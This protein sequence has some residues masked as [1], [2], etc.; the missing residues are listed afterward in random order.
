MVTISQKFE[1]LYR[2]LNPEQKKAVDHIEGPVMVV[3]GP[4]TG[5]TQVL[6]LRIANILLK[7]QVNPGNILAL[8]FSESGAATMRRRLAE[9]IGPTAYQV[10]ISTFHSFCNDTIQN[11]PDEF[12]EVVGRKPSNEVQQI[13]ILQKIIDD[14]RLQFLKPFGEPYFYLPEIR[15]SLGHLKKEGVGPEDFK[16]VIAEEKK[17]FESVDDLFYESGKYKG[18]MKGKYADLK[19]QL[20]KNEELAL[21]YAKYQTELQTAKLYDYDDMILQV[22]QTLAGNQDFLLK[23]QEKFQ[24]FLVDEQQDT[25]NAQNKV[26][27]LL[28]NFYDRPNLFVVGDE[29]Q[30]IF[31]FQ[32]AS[33]ANFIYFKK[34]YPE[35]RL[36]SLNKNYRSTQ[37]IL[38]L[39]HNLIQNNSLRLASE[40]KDLKDELFSQTE[41]SGQKVEVYEFKR[42]E[43]E[44]HFLAEKISELLKSG[45]SAKEVAVIYRDNKDAF[46]LAD[47]F[48]KYNLPFKIESSINALGDQDIQ[49]L[50]GLLQVAGDLDNEEKI[51][52]VLYANWLDLPSLDIYRLVAPGV[53]RRSLLEMITDEKRLKELKIASFEKIK[54]LS[55]NLLDWHKTSQNVGLLEIFEKVV[56]NSGFLNYILSCPDSVLKLARLNSLFKEAKKLA[57]VNQEAKLKDFVSYLATLAKHKV[58]VKEGGLG[59]TPEAIRFMTA[60][61]AKGLEF[62]YVFIV[63]AFDGHW[64]NRH[65]PQLIKLPDLTNQRRRGTVFASTD[66]TKTLFP[67]ASRDVNDDERRLFYVALTRARKMA[68]IS[69]ALQGLD[70]REH[71]ASQ[72]ISEIKPE[73]K[74]AGLSENYE[75]DFDKQSAGWQISLKTSNT[76]N[77]SVYEKEYLQEL[78]KKRGLSATAVNNFLSCPWKYFYLNLLRIPKAKSRYQVYGSAVHA[79]LKS[80]FDQLNY[81]KNNPEIL[82]S[83]FQK[84]LEKE[85]LAQNDLETFSAK[86]AEALRKYLDYYNGNWI[87][88]TQNEF[89]VS[90]VFLNDKIKLTGSLDKIE[91]LSSNEAN[92]VDYKTGKAVSRNELEGKTKNSTGDYKR[93]L[94]F[95]KLLLDSLPAVKLNMVSGELDFIEPDKKGIFH[96]ENFL[97]DTSEVDELKHTILAIADSITNFKFE[98]ERCGD[99]DCEYCQLRFNVV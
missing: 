48:G 55:A 35:A 19:K 40:I 4:G 66:E 23:L 98:N 70:G 83:D 84:A 25:N 94:V 22:A 60:H 72:F 47:T 87:A 10:H 46:V 18:K 99:R 42:P 95:Y 30:A 78:F 31:R 90:N 14:S 76:K 8:T 11:Y 67:G 86:G 16:K 32:G 34:L 6:T 59:Y 64:G 17:Y 96:K 45:V 29:K 3:A 21:I 33:L 69:Y 79:G 91:Y 27:E 58:G 65:I 88:K 13:E 5:K 26:L 7:T 68:Y 93:Q 2:Q 52:S 53:R 51:F 57:T 56:K 73:L 85:P 24:Y 44:L 1:E 89:R 82:L 61:G 43:T 77:F 63:N 36:I 71:T 37:P 92:V 81:G 74:Q 62:D 28:S 54:S 50:I 15:R 38:D 80:F 49:G 39:A 41:N 9:I 12:P 20:D 97:I 75:N